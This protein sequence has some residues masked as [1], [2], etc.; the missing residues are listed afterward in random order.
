MAAPLTAAGRWLV[1]RS[2]WNDGM[3]GFFVRINSTAGPEDM[4]VHVL[5]IEQ[6]AVLAERA[7]HAALV[8]AAQDVSDWWPAF[9]PADE[10]EPVIGLLSRIRALRAELI[11]ETK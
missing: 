10:S 1:E 2:N 9:P 8:E 5:A 4:L 3:R 11:E 7:R 6:E